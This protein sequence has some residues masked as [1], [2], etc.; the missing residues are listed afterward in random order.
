MG[1][2]LSKYRPYSSRTKVGKRGTKIATK[3]LWAWSR[4]SQQMFVDNGLPWRF[5]EHLGLTPF[6]IGQHVTSIRLQIWLHWV[7]YVSE[8]RGYIGR[9]PNRLFCSSIPFAMIF[10]SFLLRL[11]GWGAS[12]SRSICQCPA[13]RIRKHLGQGFS[14]GGLGSDRVA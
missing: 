3:V 2:I 8:K 14:S 1:K 11:L 12:M 5:G 10:G 13:T 7:V 4:V 9:V 6:V